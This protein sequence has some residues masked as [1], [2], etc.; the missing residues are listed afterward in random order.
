[1]LAQISPAADTGERVSWVYRISLGKSRTVL[2]FSVI[3]CAVLER[4]SF[5]ESRE[6][7][8]STQHEHLEFK[9]VTHEFTEYGYSRMPAV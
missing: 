1:M 2:I 5:T 8:V 7:L 9:D 4:V 3:K 6:Y